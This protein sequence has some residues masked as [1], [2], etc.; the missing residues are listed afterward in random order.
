LAATRDATF[1]LEQFFAGI[2]LRFTSQKERRWAAVEGGVCFGASRCLCNFVLHSRSCARDPTQPV[3]RSLHAFALVDGVPHC[4]FGPSKRLH[5]RLQGQYPGHCRGH[6]HALT[7]QSHPPAAC[8]LDTTST[9]LTLPSTDRTLP[10]LPWFNGSLARISLW[11]QGLPCA[12]SRQ[13]PLDETTRLM[14]GR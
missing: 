9:P 5:R 13:G 12:L 7:A 8:H 6:H 3:R 4:P 1:C 11:R 14:N 10:L 2:Y